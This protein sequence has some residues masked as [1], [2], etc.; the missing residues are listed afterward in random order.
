MESPAH[1]EYAGNGGF[2]GSVEVDWSAGAS[3]PAAQS[4]DSD[5]AGVNVKS[6]FTGLSMAMAYSAAIFCESSSVAS[7]ESSGFPVC[8]QRVSALERLSR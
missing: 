3:A 8:I 1:R 5:I 6:C 2:V 4:T 7:R